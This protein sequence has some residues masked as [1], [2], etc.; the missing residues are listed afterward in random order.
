MM[1]FDL[2]QMQELDVSNLGSSSVSF[3]ARRIFGN[4]H[5]GGINLDVNA[6]MKATN[7]P[8]DNT[9]VEARFWK[10]RTSRDFPIPVM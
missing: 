2:G 7:L 8:F 6:C 5:I 4:Y 9:L 10:R 1:L 3:K